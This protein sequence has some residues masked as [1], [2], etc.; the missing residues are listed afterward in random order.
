MKILTSRSTGYLKYLEWFNETVLTDNGNAVLVIKRED[1]MKELKF[2]NVEDVNN[3][4]G[5]L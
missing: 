3:S 4:I 1:K 2:E 5:L